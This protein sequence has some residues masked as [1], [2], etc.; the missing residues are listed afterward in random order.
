MKSFFKILVFTIITTQLNY[1]QKTFENE[2]GS[3]YML[4]HTLKTSNKIDVISGLQ[5]HDFK[6]F[7]NMNLWFFYAGANYH[8]NKTTTITL[9]HCFLDIDKTFAT[10]GDNHLFENRPYLQ[11]KHKN[12]SSKLHLNHRFRYEIRLL[13]YKG[14]HNT[15]HRFRYRLAHKKNLNKLLFVTV[16]NEIFAN[17]K[18]ALF[19]ENRFYF[20]LGFNVSK[21][22]NIQIGYLNHEINN[23]NLNRLQISF[24]IK[25]NLV[26][27]K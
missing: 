19:T 20:A 17:L 3:W 5:I 25:T 23:M 8:L 7:D 16:S 24:N 26:N 2:F 15:L 12:T 6:V 4:N 10:N 27:A 22:N 21:S 18:G 14:T 1:A 11:L 13:N 9:A